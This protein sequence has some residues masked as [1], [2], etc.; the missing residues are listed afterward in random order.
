VYEEFV[1]KLTRE[2]G[3]LRQGMDA[4]GS[5]T[6]EIGAMATESQL[7]IVERH[8]DDAVA[9]GART[10]TGG[11]RKPDGLFYEPTVLTGVDHSMVC[12]REETFGPTLPVMK[13]ANEEE[14]IRLANDSPYG[15]AASVFS[16]DPERADRVARRL[17][18]GAVNINSVLTAMM[19]MV[20]P[21]GGWKSSGIGGRNGGAAG[22]LK[23]C[24]EQAIIS[25]RFTLK[26]EPQWYPHSPRSNRAMALLV[27]L[28]GAHDWRRRLGRKG[29]R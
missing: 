23:F 26:A 16:G 18:A 27:R 28:T 24:R 2:V 21:S 11:R 17:E 10:L 5:F 14:A 1:A 6:T 29:R 13:V 22:I 25:E 3:K 15:L 7:Q 19:L 12:M 20:V 9:H 8:V 4:D